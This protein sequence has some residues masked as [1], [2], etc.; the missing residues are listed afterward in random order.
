V[1]NTMEILEV[2]VGSKRLTDDS[3]FAYEVSGDTVHQFGENS[4]SGRLIGTPTM[5]LG[6]EGRRCF[7]S[8]SC[9][10]GQSREAV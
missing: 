5:R 9:D 8:P 6:M 1:R 10:L 2:E 3:E 7:P 4:K